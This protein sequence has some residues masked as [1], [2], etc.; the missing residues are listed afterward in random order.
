MGARSEYAMGRALLSEEF[1]V[2]ATRKAQS[3]AAGVFSPER[4]LR[5]QQADPASCLEA[6][7]T[8]WKSHAGSRLGAVTPHFHFGGVVLA[9]SATMRVRTSFLLLT[10][11]VTPLLAASADAVP[12]VFFGGDSGV[13]STTPR[14]WVN[15]DAA[16]ASF[17]AAVLGLGQPVR[18]IDFEGAPVGNFTSLALGGGVTLTLSN[19]YPAYPAGIL[20]IPDYF[21]A[22]NTTPGGAR[23]LDFVTQF[24]A[25]GDS[26]T[27]SATF[28]F[29]TP[30]DA[31]G[32]Y[33]SGLNPEYV[34]FSLQ[35]VDGSLR[36]LTVP[37]VNFG[38]EFFGF[39]DPG[40]LISSVTMVQAFDNTVIPANTYAYFVGVDD[41]VYASVPEPGT[42]LLVGSG[43]AALGL[44]QRRK[45]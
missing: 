23:Y 40:S 13:V 37:G 45:A 42:L 19:T 1:R 14:P 12:L 18:S 16:A 36:V 22:F 5:L 9:V 15:S 11:L 38:V 28:D 2:T 3:G 33:F 29:A 27:A 6:V 31:F 17:N 39:V 20:N 10:L 8:G 7:G 41:I 24:V 4:R 43:L 26:T 35:F 32:A 25:P 30:V 34:S 44:R 21:G